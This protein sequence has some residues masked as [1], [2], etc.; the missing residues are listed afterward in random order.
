MNKK[1]YSSAIKKTPYKYFI[2]KKIAK[3]MFSGQDRNEVYYECFE[4]N[5]IGIDSEQRRREITNVVY[6]RL[7]S[8]DTYLLKEFLE[9]DITTSKFLLVYAIAKSDS[10]FFDFMYEVY[11]E[12][13]IGN[14]NFISID[15]FD[16]FFIS[17]QE[18]DPIVSKWGHFTLECLTKGYRNILV[19]SGIGK[20]VARNIES[21][22]VIIHPDVK[23]YIIK[24]GDYEYLRAITGE[25]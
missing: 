18:F 4:K 1:P 2:S 15:D 19:E 14:K 12:S 11:R 9:S 3:L 24:I 16:N 20:R 6:S 21:I 7:L 10:L 17:K 23:N 5:I 13:L 8:F 22:K 25:K